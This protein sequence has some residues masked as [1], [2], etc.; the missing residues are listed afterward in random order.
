MSFKLE[1]QQCPVCKSY[2]F[3]DDDIVFC[4]ECGAPHHRDCYKS[5]GHCGLKEYHG[6]DK[7]YKKPGQQTQQRQDNSAKKCNRCSNHIADDAIYCPYCGNPVNQSYSPPPTPGIYT[8]YD[9]YGGVSPADR[10]DDVPA[11]DIK[12]FVAF[13]TQRYLPL[14]KRLSKQRRVNWNFA[15]F[16]FPVGWFFF[17]KQYRP[18]IMCLLFMI[19]AGLCELPLMLEISYLREL[20]PVDATRQ[21]L[22][23]MVYEN[24]DKIGTF[25]IVMT[26]LS[27]A[28]TLTVRFVSALFGD[29]FYKNHA[30]STIK[31]IK[32]NTDSYSSELIKKGGISPLWFAISMMLTS[33]L[34]SLLGSLVL[35]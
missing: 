7:Q 22:F 33:F 15:A 26:L 11:E 1:G 4:P 25:P 32:R 14:F 8:Y 6:T 27:I 34:P 30:I 18:G 35:Y 19:A 2:L 10:I 17:R 12:N 5:I 16:L 20:L 29:F 9:P 24:I 23:R 3:E 28:I 13:N 21:Q 31:I